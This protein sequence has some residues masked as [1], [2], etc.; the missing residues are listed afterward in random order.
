MQVRSIG[1]ETGEHHR[2]LSPAVALVGISSIQGPSRLKRF[3]FNL[4]QIDQ[5]TLSESALLAGA[6]LHGV[7]VLQATSVLMKEEPRNSIIEVSLRD[8]Y[9]KRF[10]SRR[11]RL[12]ETDQTA[13]E[14]KDTEQRTN[15]EALL[16]RIGTID[17]SGE[18]YQSPGYQRDLSIKFHWGHNHRFDSDLA[19]KGRM[20]DR[21]ISVAAE[22]LEGFGLPETHFQNKAVLDVGCWTGGTTLM[23]KMLGAGEILVLEEVRKYAEATNALAIG[24]YR[25]SDVEC[26]PISLYNLEEGQFDSVYLPGV[27][28]HL[29][30]PVLGLRCLFNR[31]CDGG[32]ILIESAG[33]R[34]DQ[35]MCWFKGSQTHFGETEEHDLNR[36]GW[37]WFWP[38]ASCLAA[39]M[40]EA[41]FDDIRVFFSPA[42]KRVFGYGRRTEYRDI[43]RTGLS[44]VDIE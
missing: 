13:Y 37:A 38:S 5:E 40:L 12:E 25:F 2:R 43:T 17:W 30:D 26:A 18:G 36:G 21:H 3:A 16:A 41:G 42:S 7:P 32:D 29:S 35:P 23:L 44:V 8:D 6:T 24:I 11:A 9:G 20:G 39:W 27:I 28:Y 14:L 31:L 33:I 4:V 34:H 10:F 22:F 15:A 1:S 19:V